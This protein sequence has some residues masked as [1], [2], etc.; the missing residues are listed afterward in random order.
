MHARAVQGAK[1][2]PSPVKQ[3][4]SE[5]SVTQSTSFSGASASQAARSSMCPGS[6][7]SNR[8]PWIPLSLLM[9]A[10]TDNSS[11]CDAPSGSAKT[12]ASMPTA[13]QRFTAPRS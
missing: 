5:D 9:E 6:G 11:P 2:R 12:R 1:P 10:M 4:Q 7:L 13:P 3:P 8:Q